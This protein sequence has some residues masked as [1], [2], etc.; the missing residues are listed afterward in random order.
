MDLFNRFD[1][2]FEKHVKVRKDLHIEENSEEESDLPFP[3]DAV[4]Q[5]LRVTR[6]VLENCTNKHFYTS[7]EV[8][9]KRESLV[10]LLYMSLYMLRCLPA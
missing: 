4:L 8:N 2:F 1:G 6:L 10:L 3:K 5:V 7:Y 9:K